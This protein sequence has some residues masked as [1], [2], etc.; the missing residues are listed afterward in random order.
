M[1]GPNICARC[2]LFVYLPREIVSW[3]I[4]VSEALENG[5]RAKLLLQVHDE[6]VLEAPVGEVE[7][8]AALVKTCMEGAA[9]LRV[10]LVASVG[11]GDNWLDAK[12]G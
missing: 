3:M 11:T 2:C 9:V 6:L 7:P 1:V 10:P 12:S 5:Y 8:V 4:R